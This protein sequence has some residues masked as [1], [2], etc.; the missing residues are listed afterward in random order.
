MP[1]PLPAPPNT[2]VPHQ[3]EPSAPMQPTPTQLQPP[4]V[5]YRCPVCQGRLGSID[6]LA[7]GPRPTNPLSLYTNTSSLDL[8][9]SL[10]HRFSRARDG[11]VN[12]MRSGR[13]V[14]ILLFASTSLCMQ[15]GL[16][17][18]SA[19]ILNSLRFRD[20]GLFL[21]R[22][23]SIDYLKIDADHTDHRPALLEK[24]QPATRRGW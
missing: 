7:S 5:S 16:I 21:T 22:E 1:T 10:G 9:C 11:H 17:Y 24:A 15:L 8:G 4:E 18:D 23:Q 3:L 12:L 2:S 14:R 13:K 19:S 6:M 20:C